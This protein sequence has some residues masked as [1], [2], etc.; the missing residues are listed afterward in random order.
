VHPSE[1]LPERANDHC[2]VLD[3]RSGDSE[4]VLSGDVTATVEPAI[5]AALAPTAAQLVLQVPHHGSKTSSS[6]ALLDALKPMLA[7]VSAGYRNQFH[8]PHPDIVARYATRGISLLNTTQ[9]GF[10]DLRFGAGAPPQI[11]ERGRV[12]RHPYW[13]E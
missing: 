7:L 9:S 6:E 13:R 5:A 3:V 11:I 12:D 2:C 10:V 8:H 4:L 1:P